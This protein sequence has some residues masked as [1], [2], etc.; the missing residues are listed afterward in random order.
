MAGNKLSADK[1]V[2]IELLEQHAA[3]G[4][5]ADVQDCT[6]RR[7]F[8][9][10]RSFITPY[11]PERLLAVRVAGDSMIEEHINDSDIAVFHPGITEG[12]GIYA[13]SIGSSFAVKRADFTPQ[14]ITFIS[15]NPAA[16]PGRS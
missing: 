9:V 3:A 16:S 2:E 14:T 7:Y 12:N 5:S 6:G 4:H 1:T 13:V 10:P 8:Q 15:A 11:K